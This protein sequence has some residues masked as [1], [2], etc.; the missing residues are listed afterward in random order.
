MWTWKFWQQTLER[1]VKT[2]AQVVLAFT[3]GNGLGL[4]DVAWGHVFQVAGLATL[5][6]ALTSIVS[7]PFGKDSNSPSIV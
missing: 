2:F 6:S 3:T 1:A 4:L 7:L 5:I